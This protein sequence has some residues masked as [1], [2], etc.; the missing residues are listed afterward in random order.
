MEDNKDKYRTQEHLILDVLVKY[1]G[2]HL[3]PSAVEEIHEDLMNEIR[4]G[5]CAWAFK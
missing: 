1:C 4:N 5:N 3:S 2:K